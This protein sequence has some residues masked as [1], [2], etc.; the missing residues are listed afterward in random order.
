VRNVPELDDHFPNFVIGGTATATM[1][2]RWTTP[3]GQRHARWL[4][5]SNSDERFGAFASVV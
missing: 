5:R 1:A 2:S 4:G 3:L